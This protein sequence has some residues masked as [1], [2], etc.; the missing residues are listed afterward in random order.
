MEKEEG[1]VED[2]EGEVEKEMVVKE[3]KKRRWFRWRE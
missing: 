3:K 2:E 1:E